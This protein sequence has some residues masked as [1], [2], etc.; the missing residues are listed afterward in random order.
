PVDPTDPTQLSGAFVSSTLTD[1]KGR[2]WVASFG[3]GIAMLEKHE[4]NGR[5]HF[6]RF[7]LRD[8]LPHLGVDKL[9]ED[10]FGNIWASTDDGIAVIDGN[11]LTI[12]SLQSPQGVGIR[13]FFTSA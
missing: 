4:A 1:Q 2:L 6:R 13:T 7:G 10:R 5:W 3:Y 9:L 11:K 8:G 12:H